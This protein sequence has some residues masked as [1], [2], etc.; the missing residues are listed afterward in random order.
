MP[1][2][3]IYTFHRKSFTESCEFYVAKDNRRD[4]N[5]LCSILI[6]LLISAYCARGFNFNNVYFRNTLKECGIC[7]IF[8]LYKILNGLTRI[9]RKSMNIIVNEYQKVVLRSHLQLLTQANMVKRKIHQIMIN[10]LWRVSS[11]MNSW[12]NNSFFNTKNIKLSYAIEGEGD[13]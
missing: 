7:N 5:R 10:M 9:R 1:N 3:G 13:D 12:R 2:I 11:S 8:S 6:E 4:M